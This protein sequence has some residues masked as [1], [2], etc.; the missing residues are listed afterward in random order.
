M[1][2][3][4]LFSKDLDRVKKYFELSKI[5]DEKHDKIIQKTA[6]IFGLPKIDKKDIT[7]IVT[8]TRGTPLIRNKIAE[9]YGFI[10]KLKILTQQKFAI[11]DKQGNYLGQWCEI[12]GNRKEFKIIQKFIDE[13]DLYKNEFGLNSIPSL[14][15][16]ILNGY[17][18][19]G[20][21]CVLKKYGVFFIVQN[22]NIL[23]T[24]EFEKVFA[25]AT[26]YKM[27]EF[28]KFKEELNE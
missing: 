12:K 2:R 7:T 14:I 28:Y 26:E 25:D 10:N 22:E 16:I 23:K 3:C 9:K 20:K 1:E 5:N 15:E 13:L 17:T 19:K 8:T 6:K 18:F 24:K 4:F 11:H 27:S 21:Y